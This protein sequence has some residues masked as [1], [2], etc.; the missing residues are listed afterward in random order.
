MNAAAQIVR[1]APKAQIH[2]FGG[3]VRAG[4]VPADHTFR[5][6]INDTGKADMLR[7]LISG[8][9]DQ[10]ASA[11]ELL[12][13]I[14]E[15][16][17]QS[18]IPSLD[19]MEDTPQRVLATRHD[20]LKA[21][22]LASS[23]RPAGSLAFLGPESYF[24]LTP[25]TPPIKGH[26][27]EPKQILAHSAQELA[28]LTRD[29]IEELKSNSVNPRLSTVA[30]GFP[31]A[32]ES[33]RAIDFVLKH[34]DIV[35][36]IRPLGG[37]NGVNEGDLPPRYLYPIETNS[38]PRTLLGLMMDNFAA[39]QRTLERTALT[40][41][42]LN[43]KS[44]GFTADRLKTDLAGWSQPEIDNL[45]GF[46]QPSSSRM[47]LGTLDFTDKLFSTGHGDFSMML[48]LYNAYKA[49]SESGIKYF[50]YGNCDE[51][52]YGAD[53]TVIGMAKHLF[54]KGYNMLVF[55]APNSNNQLGG[56]AVRETSNPERQFLCEGTVLPA[57]MVSTKQNPSSVN[58]TFYVMST[59]ALAEA[60]DSLGELDAAID[61]KML[62]PRIGA[63]ID[64]WAGSE[65]TGRLKPAFVLAPRS[66]FFLGVKSLQHT[67]SDDIPPELSLHPLGVSHRMSYH[68]FVRHMANTF[69]NVIA[70]MIAGDSKVTEAVFNMG[71]SYFID[72]KLM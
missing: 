10:N 17:A 25:H 60:T 5:Q 40:L 63:C 39:T 14:R 30:M 58:T 55:V 22:V 12:P 27:W 3:H 62:G 20:E 46:V 43:S 19:A 13:G 59:A 11:R 8:L 16:E 47:F 31:S 2:N 23:R 54:G 69:P 45:F 24:T 33:S 65:W 61:I 36:R 28:G 15:M 37:L 32:G 42:M 38:G 26:T 7:A 51:F 35:G 41:C 18:V 9:F 56:G 70:A 44:V 64:S 71:G 57:D 4:A 68:D 72:P 48:S 67:H 21:I 29:G 50:Q 6:P 1:F 66:G 34:P 53:P 49:M 52:L